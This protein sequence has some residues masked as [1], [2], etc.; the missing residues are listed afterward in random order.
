MNNKETIQ[1]KQAGKASV[2]NNDMLEKHLRAPWA[3]DAQIVK[4]GKFTI[5]ECGADER[6]NRIWI[7]DNQEDAG[8]FDAAGLEAHIKL[9]YDKYF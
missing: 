1:P 5:S 7:D 9:Y 8:E 4:I 6:G 3:D 2:T